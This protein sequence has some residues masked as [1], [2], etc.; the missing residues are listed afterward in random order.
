MSLSVVA[1]APLMRSGAAN[2]GVRLMPVN[3]RSVMAGSAP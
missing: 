2:L 1:P 3:E